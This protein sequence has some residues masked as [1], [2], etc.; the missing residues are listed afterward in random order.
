MLKRIAAICGIILFLMGVGLA[1]YL[2]F[3]TTKALGLDRSKPIPAPPFA[4]ANVLLCSIS[5]IHV[6]PLMTLDET[7]AVTIALANSDRTRACRAN[8]SLSA[9]EFDISPQ[10]TVRHLVVPPSQTV[11]IGWILSPRRLGTFTIQVATGLESRFLGISV[12]ND[13]GLNTWQAQL[14]SVI[15]TFLGPIASAAW[16]YDRWKEH[17]RRKRKQAGSASTMAEAAHPESVLSP[18]SKKRERPTSSSV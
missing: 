15:G 11:T 5:Q 18:K 6:A 2:V 14:L 10:D 3:Q 13:F 12:T 8:V 7:Q 4:S 17:R 1:L 16:W 9:P